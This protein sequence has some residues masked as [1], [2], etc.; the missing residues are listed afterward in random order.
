MSDI[1]CPFCGEPIDTDEFHYMEPYSWEE[2]FDLFLE[3][4]CGFVDHAWSG[5]PLKKCN[6]GDD[7][8]ELIGVLKQIL[9]SDRDAIIVEMEDLDV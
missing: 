9:G 4:G 1:R 3:Y 2:A 5:A 6:H 8:D 7:P